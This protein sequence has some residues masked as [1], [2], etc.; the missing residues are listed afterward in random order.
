LD[1][2]KSSRWCSKYYILCA[3]GCRRL[4]TFHWVNSNAH[5]VHQLMVRN[6]DPTCP[7]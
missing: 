7:C 1:L 2:Q 5:M 6:N 3:H 4:L